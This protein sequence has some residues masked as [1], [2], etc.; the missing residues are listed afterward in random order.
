MRERRMATRPYYRKQSDRDNAAVAAFT[1]F[2]A[3]LVGGLIGATITL[4]VVG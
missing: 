1:L 3:V 4:A 2:L